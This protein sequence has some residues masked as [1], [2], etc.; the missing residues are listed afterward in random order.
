M[1]RWA[2]STDAARPGGSAPDAGR[3]QRGERQQLR[4]QLPGATVVHRLRSH[5]PDPRVAVLGVVPIE[6]RDAER[7]RVLDAAETIREARSIFERLE[8][9]LR[10]AV[11]G[12]GVGRECDLVTPR[13]ESSS[14]TG[15][16]VIELP[17]SAWIVSF[18]GSAPC[19]VI[20]S[21][22][23]RLASAASSR[24]AIIQLTT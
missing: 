5:H 15:L 8:L 1:Q 7:A 16:D 2:A 20:D 10:I 17:R 21:W 13:S 9:R 12:R 4:L 22:I 19:L 23:K 3:R 18:L 14:A 6:E 24:S 11:V